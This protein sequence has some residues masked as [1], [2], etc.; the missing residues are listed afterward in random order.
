[1]GGSERIEPVVSQV[2]LRD[3]SMEERVGFLVSLPPSQIITELIMR[4]EFLLS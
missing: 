4:P 3:E 2:T 1:M